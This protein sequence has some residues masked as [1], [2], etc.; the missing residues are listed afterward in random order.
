MIMTTGQEEVPVKR[1]IMA[2]HIDIV[3]IMC[4]EV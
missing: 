3:K 2:Y 1:V 4:F